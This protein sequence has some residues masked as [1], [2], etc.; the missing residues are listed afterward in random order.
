MTLTFKR[1]NSLRECIHFYNV[2]LRTIMKI[3]G[4]IEFGRSCFDKDKKIL[5]PEF[6]LETNYFIYFKTITLTLIYCIIDLKFGP[7]L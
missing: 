4:L 1:K 2:F 6:Q 7:A 5:I 3:L